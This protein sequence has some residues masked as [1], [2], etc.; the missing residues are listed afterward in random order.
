MAIELFQNRAERF[1]IIRDG[2]AVLKVTEAEFDAMKKNGTSPLLRRLWD[3]AKKE[4][5]QGL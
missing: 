2:D 3:Q 1:F 5:Q 4:R